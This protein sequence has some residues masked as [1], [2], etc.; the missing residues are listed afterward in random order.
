MGDSVR[1]WHPAVPSVREVLHATFEQHA[2]PLHTHADWTVLLIDEGVVT[3]DLERNAHQAAPASITLLPPHVPHD[4][5]SAV[6]GEGFRKRVLYLSEEWLPASM[7]DAAVAAPTL[8][9]PQAVSMVAGIH[10][11]LRSPFDAM[12]A[13]GGV[14]AL[15]ELVRQH[16]GLP[17]SPAPDAPL[18]RRLREML[19]DRLVESFTIAEAARLL[20]AHPSHLVRAFSQAYG[21]APYRY[22]TG[23][24]VDRARRLLLDGLPPAEV[25]VEAGFHDQAHL[26]RHFRR[27]LG[28]TPGTF[29]A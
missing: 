1:A 21:I 17:S 14:L 23:R 18:A 6:G 8:G 4:G 22:L 29:A 10:A 7:A 11:A 24:R 2:Y 28:T 3:Y 27:V 26:T 12:A 15:Q 25:A 19:D 16:L 9:D 13:E 5:R 20:G